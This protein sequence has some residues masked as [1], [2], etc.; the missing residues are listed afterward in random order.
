MRRAYDSIIDPLIPAIRR[1]L[2]AIIARLHRIDFGKSV[3]PMSGMGGGPSLYMKDLVDKL[4][5]VKSEIFS[6][7]NVGEDSRTWS[8]H[9]LLP[10]YL[11]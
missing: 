1:D 9:A 10:Q 4:S 2:S 3:D 5:F 6:R 8:V 7:F 11:Y